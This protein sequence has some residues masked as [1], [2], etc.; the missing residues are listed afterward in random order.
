[1]KIKLVFDR[2][3]TGYEDVKDLD[4][5]AGDVLMGRYEV[6]SVLGSGVFAKVVKAKD[7]LSQTEELTCLKVI[8]NNKD[9]IDQ[10]FDEMK[11]LK[12]IKANCDPDA[13]YLLNFK[14][15]TYYK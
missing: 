5:K 13:N 2:E 12:L 11:L 15:A 8:S 4:L 6:V 9:F 1:M 10:S 3:K 14:S 7:L